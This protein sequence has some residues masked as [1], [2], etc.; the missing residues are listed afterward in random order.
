MGGQA[1]AVIVE[2]LETLQSQSGETRLKEIV[3]QASKDRSS[4]WLLEESQPCPRCLVLARRETGCD[5]IVCRCGCS[6]CFRCGGPCE[7]F[8]CVCQ[9]IN[10]FQGEVAFAA[11]LRSSE[12]SPCAWL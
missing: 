4:L 10:N 11:W 7:D 9:Y 5:H 6:F 3:D 12:Y 1:D 2:R 8:S